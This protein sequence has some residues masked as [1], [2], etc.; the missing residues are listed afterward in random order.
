MKTGTKP[1]TLPRRGLDPNRSTR[2]GIFAAPCYAS[3]AY[4]CRH[5]VFIRLSI[6]FVHSF[7]TNKHI[8]K[9]FFTSVIHTILV[10][11][12]KRHGNTLTRTPLTGVLNAGGVGKNM[13]PSACCVRIDRPATCNTHSCDRPWQVDDTSRW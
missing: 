8:F 10:F 2:P 5:A 6:T 7:K 1:L 11:R 13:A 12:T 9:I 4:L 3:A